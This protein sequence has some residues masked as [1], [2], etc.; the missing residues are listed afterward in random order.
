MTPTDAPPRTERAAAFGLLG[1]GA[2]M[3]AMA[4]TLDPVGHD[5]DSGVIHLSPVQARQGLGA[6]GL[7][8]LAAGAWSLRRGARS[9]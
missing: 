8:F 4:L 5:P 2:L 1:L 6:F 3:L 9:G 7:A